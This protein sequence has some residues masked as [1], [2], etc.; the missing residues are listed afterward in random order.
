[1]TIAQLTA[2]LA[3]IRCGSFTAAALELD[4]TQASVSELIARL[5]R[6]LGVRLFTRGAR[7]LTPT[8]AAIALQSHAELALSAIS[9]GVETIAAINSLE[10]GICTFGVLRNAAYYDLAD[11]VQRFHLLYPNVKVR[12]V[13]LNSALV[14]ESIAANEIEAGLIV[15]PV[16][17]AGLRI[18]PLFRDEVL[19]A[20]TL[21]SPNDGPVHIAELARA[22]LV[23]YDAYAGW[24]DPTR[25]QLLE[26]AR[27]Q[28]I[29]IDPA[30]EVEHVET[31]LSLVA[32]GA[33][34]TIV[35]RTIAESSTFPPGILVTPFTD[36]LFDTIALAQR[37]GAYLSPATQR[38]AELAESTLLTAVGEHVGRSQ[39]G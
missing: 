18:T 31:A 17:E 8:D 23:L 21:R 1:M 10:G 13:G 27:L 24:R 30:I 16:D 20:S 28:G 25:R 37:E 19:Y 7:R 4:S 38:L 12:L 35:S 3:A 5:E 36:P 33:A 26:R 39:A 29:T 14:A 6:E 22:K 34:D 9:N 11:L 15:L 2:F 32:A